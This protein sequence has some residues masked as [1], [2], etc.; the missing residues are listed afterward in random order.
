MKHR[1]FVT[2][3]NS[4]RQKSVFKVRQTCLTSGHQL[5]VTDVFKENYI[6]ELKKKTPQDSKKIYFLRTYGKY[7]QDHRHLSCWSCEGEHVFGRKQWTI[8]QGNKWVTEE[9]EN[10][11]QIS[12]SFHYTSDI[13]T[14]H[15]LRIGLWVIWTKPFLRTCLLKVATLNKIYFLCPSSQ[16]YLK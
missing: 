1:S 3:R 2:K 11:P 13:V 12:A 8:Q 9:W 5:S 14:E 4:I 6:S 10:S 7:C 16:K 15:S